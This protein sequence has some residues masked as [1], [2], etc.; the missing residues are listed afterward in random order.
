MSAPELVKS[1]RNLAYRVEPVGE[2]P[3][4]GPTALD[5]WRKLLSG[6]E[7]DPETP[8]ALSRLFAGWPVQLD[9]LDGPEAT[10][11]KLRSNPDDD[12]KFVVRLAGLGAENEGT[13]GSRR[14]VGMI[15][16]GAASKHKIDDPNDPSSPQ[17]TRYYP[18]MPVPP[19]VDINPGWTFQLLAE[20]YLIRHQ[21]GWRL[22]AVDDEEKTPPTAD[23][24]QRRATLDE[25]IAKHSEAIRINF[26]TPGSP[27]PASPPGPGE[28]DEPQP[29]PG[30][31]SAP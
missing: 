30:G 13:G 14:L 29:S 19:P 24:E 5:V 26:G 25:A 1:A 21:P 27:S 28:K 20:D 4:D 12:H 7:A 15:A 22:V 6:I 31:S 3:A 10:D 18:G 9:R 11:E 23:P 16:C 2:P 8:A 17:P